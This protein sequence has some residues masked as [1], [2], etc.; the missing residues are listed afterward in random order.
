MVT[1]LLLPDTT[2]LDLAEVDRMH[3]YLLAGE[4]EAYHG[5]ARAPAN[6]SMFERW[7]AAPPHYMTP[8]PFA[9]APCA[10]RCARRQCVGAVCTATGAAARPQVGVR[11]EAPPE[12]GQGAPRAAGHSRGGRRGPGMRQRL[13]LTSQTWSPSCLMALVTVWCALILTFA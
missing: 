12:A 13:E 9:P 2:S 8:A 7:S 3:R 1:V 4:L 10:A 5:D 11:R 6:L